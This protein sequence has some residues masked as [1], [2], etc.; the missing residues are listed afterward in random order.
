MML[1]IMET[2]HPCKEKREVK[3]ER[4]RCPTRICAAILAYSI[5]AFSRTVI[6]LR[7]TLSE[8][9]RIVALGHGMTEETILSR[10]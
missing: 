7:R 1:S 6:N 9:P 8:S 10:V 4:Q 5:A 2:S 3:D